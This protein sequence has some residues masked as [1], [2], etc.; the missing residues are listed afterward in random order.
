IERER[1][2]ERE[3]Q[4]ASAFA[5]GDRFAAFLPPA[6]LPLNIILD[7]ERNQEKSTLDAGKALAGAPARLRG[8]GGGDE[9]GRDP[10]HATAPG[11][12]LPQR[13]AASGAG[14]TPGT[15]PRAAPAP[16]LAPGAGVGAGA[17]AAAA[18]AAAARRSAGPKAPGSLPGAA[19]QRAREAAAAAPGARDDGAGQGGRDLFSPPLSGGCRRR[20]IC[21][22]TLPGCR[23]DGAGQGGRLFGTTGNCAACSKLIPAFEMVMRA[24]DNVYHLDCFA[25]QLCNQRFCVGDKFFLKN[26]MILCQMDYEEGQLNGSFESQV[27]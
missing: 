21:P 18:A 4:A 6:P 16:G 5:F 9:E 14:G 1:A 12:S 13:V 24:R 2:S 15:P 25:C 27:Q 26:N 7:L 17:E 11:P 23:D 22:R 3:R 8:G 10:P 19:P 20:S